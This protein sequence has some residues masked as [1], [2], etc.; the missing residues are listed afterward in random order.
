MTITTK[1]N[2]VVATISREIN[3]NPD[4]A[5]HIDDVKIYEI[6]RESI[7]RIAK[8]SLDDFLLDVASD[9]FLNVRDR[10]EPREHRQQIMYI[11]LT[12][13]RY[14]SLLKRT[15]KETS[16]ATAGLALSMSDNRNPI[17]PVEKKDVIRA[18]RSRLKTDLQR[19]VLDEILKKNTQS[20]IARDLGV[21]RE[22]VSQLS[23]RIR[24]YAESMR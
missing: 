22:R 9:V 1:D 20:E 3:I 13:A 21:T 10:L 23:R 17:C 8:R 5:S 16:V 18:L 19:H 4:E 14:L 11:F 2:S 7:R 24:Y 12:C 6:I 15:P